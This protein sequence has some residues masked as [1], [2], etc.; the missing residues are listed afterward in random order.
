ML[1]RVREVVLAA[2]HV[3]DAHRDV[4]DDV[5]KMEHRV[6]VR[7]HD[8]EVL[9]LGPLDAAPDGVVDDLGLTGDLEVNRAVLL[10]R[11]TGGL[12]F[13]EML[14]VDGRPFAL[15]AGAESA[16]DPRSLVPAE[17]E[18]REAVVDDVEER[19]GVALLV[20]VLDAQDEDAAGVAGVK[21]VEQRRAGAADVEEPGG[22]GAKRTRTWDM[23]YAE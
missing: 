8:H 22:T 14:A 21:P 2:Y 1:A 3:G 4:V 9:L 10:K 13:F 17:A 6:P 18:P 23:S 5:D 7:A 19:L 20:R 12:Q 16:A 11:A 15:A